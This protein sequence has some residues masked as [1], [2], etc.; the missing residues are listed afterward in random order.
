MV[1]NDFM[2]DIDVLMEEHQKKKNEII[3]FKLDSIIKQLKRNNKTLH[4]I[5]KIINN[6]NIINYTNV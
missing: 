2:K 1:L 6:N 3:Y 4:K 5:K